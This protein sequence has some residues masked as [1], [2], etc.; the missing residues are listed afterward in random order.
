MYINSGQAQVKDIDT[1]RNEQ[2]KTRKSQLAEKRN[3]SNIGGIISGNGALT[4]RDGNAPGRYNRSSY[5]KHKD[6]MSG[7]I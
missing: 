2:T 3:S 6:S 5:I 4:D 1:L 7:V